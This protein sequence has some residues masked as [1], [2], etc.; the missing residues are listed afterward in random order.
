MATLKPPPGWAVCGVLAVFVISGCTVS[1]NAP[2]QPNTPASTTPPGSAPGRTPVDPV[3]FCNE[4][5][6]Q[7]GDPDPWPVATAALL[8]HQLRFT[9]GTSTQH[10]Q[11]RTIW[12]RFT[13]ITPP[14]YRAE[15]IE[16]ALLADGQGAA[17]VPN[18]QDQW[19][20][21]VAPFPDGALDHI[22]VHE[23]AHLISVRRSETIKEPDSTVCPTVQ[24]GYGC[25]RPGS[26][27][28]QFTRTFWSPKNTKKTSG[29]TR[30]ALFHNNPDEYVTVY[31]ATNSAEDFAESFR[32]FIFDHKPTTATV[33]DQK[34][35]LF[36]QSEELIQLRT[37]VRATTHPP[38]C[39]APHTTATH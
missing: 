35:N 13:Q 30:T 14:Q 16:I 6:M 7:P 9:S 24:I 1:S 20:L 18:A 21:H 2:G 26:I 25:A 15:L 32:H 28:D 38:H 36:W 29:H 31:A 37:A 22:L 8:D 34:V 11:I 19:G 23:L 4:P 17:V 10:D 33:A 5:A 27:F 3:A 39:T 12:N